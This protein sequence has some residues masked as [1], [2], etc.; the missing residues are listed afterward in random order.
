MK[1]EDEAKYQNQVFP[2]DQQ[3]PGGILVYYADGEEEIT[4]VNQYVIDLFECG[5]MEEFLEHTKGS[6]RHFVYEEDILAAE[7][8]IWEQVRRQHGFDR[9]CY[10]IRTKSGKLTSVEDFGR[11]VESEDGRPVFYVFVSELG[12]QGPVDWLTGLP[13]VDRFYKMAALEAQTIAECGEEPV[14]LAFNLVGMKSFN[15]QHGRDAGD[16]FLCAFADMLRKRYGAGACSRHRGDRFFAVVSKEHVSETVD[17]LF[18]D[19]REYNEGNSLP[20][21]VGA[22]V[23]SPED[24]IA[25]VGFER[26]AIACDSDDKS[27]IS[28]IEWYS[29][30][31]ETNEELRAYVLGNIDRCIREGHIKPYYQAIVRSATDNVCCE[32][33]LARWEDP[34]YGSLTPAQFIPILE[35]VGLLHKLDMHMIDCVLA[36][37]VVKRERGVPMVPVSVNISLK[38]LR[39]VDLAAVVN[40]KTAALGIPHSMLRIEFTESAASRDPELFRKQVDQLHAAGFKVWMDDFG[41]GYSSLNSLRMFDFDLVKLDMD[42]IS[43]VVSEKTRS[44]VAGVLRLARTLGVDTLAEGIET[45]QQERFLKNV[46]CGRLQGFKY[47]RPQPLE[48]IIEQFESGQGPGREIFSEADYWNIISSFDLADPTQGTDDHGMDGSPISELPAGILERRSGVWRLVRSNKP[49]LDF[50]THSSLLDVAVD[51]MLRGTDKQTNVDFNAAVD[52]SVA[53]GGW[54]R[55]AGRFEYDSGLR[56]YARLLASEGDAQA[57]AIASAPAIL[58]TALGLYGDVPVP[59]AVFS[60]V[61]DERNEKVV[62]LE[63]IYANSLYSEQGGYANEHLAGR[64]F[65]DVYGEKGIDVLDFFYRAAM[66]N[67]MQQQVAY[68]PRLDKWISYSIYPSPLEGCCVFAYMV[69]NELPANP[70]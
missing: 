52:R 18:E 14:A 66:L 57:F 8:S 28:H 35:G 1:H 5:S 43:D 27:W 32:E 70:R 51:A 24:D 69:L 33:A 31:M 59:Y 61:F 56:F 60:L 58:G 68:D 19:L 4:Y 7:D 13:S 67:E 64:S 55:I 29:D 46:S 48:A 54:E 63:Y 22:Y 49:F 36:D 50:L 23:C 40:E 16:A 44:V 34:E 3:A 9:I 11:L 12:Q 30:A 15:V 65:L 62:D 37:L 26:A 42:L 39:S 25:T 17:A 10:R 21:Q 20:V 2:D 38:D 6:F 53:S 47:S 41:S 45:E